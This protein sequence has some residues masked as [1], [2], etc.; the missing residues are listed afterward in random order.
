MWD[1]AGREQVSAVFG[2][3]AGLGGVYTIIGLANR[4]P[5]R[6]PHRGTGTEGAQCPPP[7]SL[8]KSDTSEVSR[9]QEG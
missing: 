7:A 9:G 4:A 8:P 3:K 5:K 6:P 1:Q 2:I